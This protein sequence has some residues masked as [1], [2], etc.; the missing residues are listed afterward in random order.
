[1][2]KEKTYGLGTRFFLYISATFLEPCKKQRN[3]VF[4]FKNAGR[5]V[6]ENA[7]SYVFIKLELLLIYF[8]L[9]YY[10]TYHS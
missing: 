10:R 8:C 9:Y 5:R 7:K 2:E 3:S 6:A 1:M 4:M